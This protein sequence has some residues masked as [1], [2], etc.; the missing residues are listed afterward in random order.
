MLQDL[1]ICLVLSTI[2]KLH[3]Q[4]RKIDPKK[5]YSTNKR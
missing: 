2:V 3:K 5:V 4:K 1:K